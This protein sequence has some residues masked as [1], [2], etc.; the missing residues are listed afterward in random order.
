MVTGCFSL[1][2]AERRAVAAFYPTGCHGGCRHRRGFLIDDR[3]T[4]HFKD[5][6]MR[7]ECRRAVHILA[8][9]VTLFDAVRHI[10]AGANVCRCAA[11]RA[12]HHDNNPRA[13][14]SASRS[15]IFSCQTFR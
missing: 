9:Q 8:L 4:Y 3:R 10:A 14:R 13:F 5:G 1:L 12:A 6:L 11:E 15:R 2:M 7:F